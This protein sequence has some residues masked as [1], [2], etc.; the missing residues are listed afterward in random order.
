MT[1]CTE[2]KTQCHS[3]TEPTVARPELRFT[4]RVDIAE[5]DTALLVL[6][7]LPGV[8]PEDLDIHLEDHELRI[9]GK[10]QP[11]EIRGNQW[12][13]EY[14]VGDF[15]RTFKV[16]DQIDAAKVSAELKNGVLTIVLPKAEAIKP[17][18]IEVKS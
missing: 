8:R 14:Q 4:P 9:T 3:P 7:D 15:E 12:L 2:N 5:T 10:C 11:R 13:Q 6:G 1:T 17:R 16:G 18:R